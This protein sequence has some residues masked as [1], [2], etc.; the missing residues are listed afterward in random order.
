[1]LQRPHHTIG[2]HEVHIWHLMADNLPGQ[3]ARLALFALLTPEEQDRMARFRHEQDR[4]LYLLSRGLMRSVLASY[5]GCRSRD[6]RFAANDFGKPILE[7]APVAH[8]PGSPKLH[9]NL[10]HS[11]GAAALAVSRG[12]EVGID[13]EQRERQIEFLALAERY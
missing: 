9:F 13:I 11:R 7:N 1:M 12:R 2:A 5:L 8:A 6:V 4:T 10:T 3:E